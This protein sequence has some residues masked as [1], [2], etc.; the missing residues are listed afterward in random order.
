MGPLQD[1]QMDWGQQ[2]CLQEHWESCFLASHWTCVTAPWPVL[3]GT[4]TASWV[5][6]QFIARTNVSR[7]V[8]WGA[9]KCDSSWVPWQVLMVAGPKPNKTVMKPTAGL[10]CFW[11]SSQ[12]YG[13]Q[14]SH[15]GPCLLSQIGPPQSW[16]PPR[17]YMFLPGSQSS[18]KC[19]SVHRWLP[20]HCCG[21]A[22][23]NSRG[24][25]IFSSCWCHL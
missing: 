21:G 3:R 23:G 5:S 2:V 11:L 8:T 16:A 18:H 7:P 24:S 14:A 13:W 22:R 15:L 25:P 17:F 10:G 19:T 20:D 9:G 1:L 12:D 6:T 4:G